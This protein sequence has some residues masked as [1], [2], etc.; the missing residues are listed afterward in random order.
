M[1]EMHLS[2]NKEYYTGKSMAVLLWPCIGLL[3]AFFIYQL[4]NILSLVGIVV[5]VVV[6]IFGCYHFT[7]Y[8]S[9]KITINEKN[10]LIKQGII[11]KEYTEYLLAHINGIV[12]TQGFWARFLNYGT[13]TL[14]VS[15]HKQPP[16]EK[17]KNPEMLKDLIYSK[18]SINLNYNSNSTSSNLLHTASPITLFSQVE[19][20]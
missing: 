6:T 10:V 18:I 14:I 1:E 4:P 11:K 16:L 7:N 3:S 2:I 5:G 20:D 13:I 9:F 17:I 15:G 19:N 8:C 12:L